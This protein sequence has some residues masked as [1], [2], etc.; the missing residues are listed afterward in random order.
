M[1]QDLQGDGATNFHN[2]YACAHKNPLGASPSRQQWQFFFICVCTGTV[3]D[4]CLGSYF[5]LPCLTRAV[6]HNFYTITLQN[7]HI[8]RIG[9]SVVYTCRCS[10][11]LSS[12]NLCFLNM[13]L[14]PTAWSAPYSDS[15]SFNALIFGNMQ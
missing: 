5:L 2:Q 4:K 6:N 12:C 13:F 7:Y 11:P 3:Q 1:K 15:N 14:E 8:C 10:A 9:Y